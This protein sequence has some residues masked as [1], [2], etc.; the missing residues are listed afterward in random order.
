MNDIAHRDLKPDNIMLDI[1]NNVVHPVIIDFGM[2]NSTNT[3]AGTPSYMPPEVKQP[4]RSTIDLVGQKAHD[5]F[6]L[7][8]IIHQILCGSRPGDEKKLSRCTPTQRALLEK[9]LAASPDK[10][11]TIKVALNEPYFTENNDQEVLG[12]GL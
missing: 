8:V 12:L 2:T 11:A 5:C 3:Y 10:R 6:S 9:L 4:T 7:G 1:N